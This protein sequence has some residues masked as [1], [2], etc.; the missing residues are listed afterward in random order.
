MSVSSPLASPPEGGFVF[1]AEITRDL[2]VTDR[3]VRKWISTERFPR[4]DGNLNGRNFWLTSTYQRW[5]SDVLAGRYRQH[6]RPNP[7]AHVA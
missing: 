6:R 1:M 7:S 2:K 5:K 3:G 4:P